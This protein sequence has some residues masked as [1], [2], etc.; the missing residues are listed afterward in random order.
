[1]C[2][3]L[4]LQPRTGG[5]DPRPSEAHSLEGEA[6]G[7]QQDKNRG[8]LGGGRGRVIGDQGCLGLGAHLP[9]TWPSMVRGDTQI[10]V[11][12]KAPFSLISQN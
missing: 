8:D 3:R 9:Q 7:L 12:A 1:M 5:C 2:A 4:Q 10:Y 11:A 6:A